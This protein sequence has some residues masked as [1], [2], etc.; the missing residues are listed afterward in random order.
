MTSVSCDKLNDALTRAEAHAPHLRLLMARHSDVRDTLAAGDLDG[1]LAIH[2]E[3]LD[4][5]E[6]VGRALRRAKGQLALA[7][8]IGDLAGLLDLEGVTHSLSDFADMALDKAIAA[9][10]EH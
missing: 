2:R 9:A 7:V 10:I 4:P 1:A 6:P 8:A 3:P 5:D